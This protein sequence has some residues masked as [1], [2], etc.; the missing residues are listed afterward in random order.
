MMRK[1]HCSMLNLLNDCAQKY[2]THR[3]FV[4]M[5]KAFWPKFKSEAP[6]PIIHIDYSENE[7]L[8]PKNEVQSAHFSGRQ[9]TLH[10]CVLYNNIKDG[11]HEFVY[12][13]SDDTTHD[14]VMTFQ[15]IEDILQKYPQIVDSRYLVVR[16]DNCSTQYKSRYTFGLMQKISEK[17]QIDIFWFYGAAGHGRGLVD[18]MS[19]FGCKAPLQNAI[20]TDDYFNT[21]QEMHTFLLG[22]F[23]N[24]KK[25]AKKSYIIDPEEN[26]QIRKKSDSR[27]EH[28]ILGSSKMHLIAVSSSGEW[29]TK[30]ILKV[31]DDN[32]MN[33]E[34]ERGA[35]SDNIE[36]E[37]D[38]EWHDDGI[39]SIN[40]DIVDVSDVSDVKFDIIE[41]DTFVGLLSPTSGFESFYL[42][43]VIEKGIA[44]ENKDY[45]H[46]HAINVG[47]KYTIGEY[48]EKVSE[49]KNNVFYNKCKKFD[50]VLIHIN[51]ITTV[52][53]DFD[54]C[55]MSTEEYLP[56]CSEML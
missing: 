38:N 14:A 25:G 13:L 51:E 3:Y 7:K 31:T 46:G 35:S 56:I 45:K 16:S 4:S 19:S 49:K 53:I 12:H 8:V 37:G 55:K 6:C 48:Y 40:N 22:H 50:N 1:R 24:D 29:M 28:V 20:I 43:K 36:I 17:H 27:H 54:G 32:V 11:D 10:C 44:K 34:I 21:A 15:I 33:L 9:H 39:E 41:E 2:L 26:A 47:Q 42:V 52:S 5:D 18:A 23:R 30:V